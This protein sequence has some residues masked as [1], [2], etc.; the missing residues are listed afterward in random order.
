MSKVSKLQKNKIIN[1]CNGISLPFEELYFYPIS[2]K[3]ITDALRIFRI[4]QKLPII[5]LHVRNNFTYEKL[6]NALLCIQKHN[7]S[8]GY[9]DLAI[10]FKI[11]S[12]HLLNCKKMNDIISNYNVKI[13][14]VIDYF[15]NY[16]E[17]LNQITKYDFIRVNFKKDF[18]LNKPKKIHLNT[19]KLARFYLSNDMDC[20]LIYNYVV[21]CDFNGL[22]ITKSTTNS[23]NMIDTDIKILN[24]IKLLLGMDK[25]D[26][27]LDSNM[28]K[29]NQKMFHLYSNQ[30]GYCFS[31]ML[32]ATYEND[33]LFQCPF[34]PLCAVFNNATEYFQKRIL[35]VSQLYN[36]SD[37]GYISD[38][39]LYRNIFNILK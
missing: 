12:N 10:E 2:E 23:N 36:C 32:K 35:I 17:F 4:S 39:I 24:E 18:S 27:F 22:Q 13:S 28:S 15:D 11:S 37:C 26:L 16:E 25:V 7:H 1:F 38:N 30:H 3:D 34:N 33:L 20:S 19:Y 5:L 9:D 8:I 29:I 6:A 14:L 31:S 21:D